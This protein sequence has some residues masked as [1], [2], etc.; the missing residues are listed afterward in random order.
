L[1]N[2]KEI[3]NLVAQQNDPRLLD[4]AKEQYPYLADK[5]IAY[6]YSPQAKPKYMLEF[7]QGGDLP[8]WAKNNKVAIEVFNSKT[9]PIDILGDY[10][11]HYGVN[12]DPKLQELYQK[13]QQS[14]D[15]KMM[16]NRYL[17]HKQHLGEKRS[18]EEW[19]KMTGVP[20]MFRGYTFD[21][22]KDA[23]QMYTPE[24]LQ[25]LDQV[26]NYLGIK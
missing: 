4:V 25:I 20:E 23:K 15:P 8:S 9:K 7:Y 26:R 24:Q 17:F 13:F 6:K 19:S 16:Q 18:P 12:T 22:W 5:D 11:S 1:A 2:D 14:L 10:V 21:Q 3:M